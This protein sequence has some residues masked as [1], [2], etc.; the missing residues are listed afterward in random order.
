MLVHILD[1]TLVDYPGTLACTLFFAGCNFRCPYC[2]NGNLV[3]PQRYEGLS[4]ISRERLF[5]FLRKRQGFLKGVVFTGGEPL[6]HEEIM[7]LN[8]AIREMGFLTKL[9]TNG[10]LPQKLREREK[11]FDYVA[12][13]VKAPPD[14]YDEATGSQGSFDNILESIEILKCR[15][16]PYEFRTTLIPAYLPPSH[17]L[18]EFFQ[19][20]KGA[21]RYR[22]QSYESHSTLDPH[23]CGGTPLSFQEIQ[24]LAD[25]YRHLVGELLL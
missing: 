15:G 11:A 6:L 10:S 23:F 13:D 14:R 22:L 9:D 16:A 3:L 25:P 2:H 21:R 20:V 5:A 1:T 12:M 4:P 17:D 7:E 19:M 18:G 8:Q 24:T